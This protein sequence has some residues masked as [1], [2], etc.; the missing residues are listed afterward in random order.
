MVRSIH[1]L[2]FSIPLFLYSYDQSDVGRSIEWISE[3]DNY[4]S[5]VSTGD[6]VQV[7]SIGENGSSVNSNG[8]WFQSANEGNNWQFVT[9]P[10]DTDDNS[11]DIS[12]TSSIEFYE[13]FVVTDPSGYD[14]AFQIKCEGTASYTNLPYA[15]FTERNSIQ[16]SPIS[17]HSYFP[18]NPSTNGI[19]FEN[20]NDL[21]LFYRLV[22]IAVS[23]NV[24]GTDYSSNGDFF[25]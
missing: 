20:L 12:V 14:F 3:Q 9:D 25:A 15:P 1:C 18:T 4:N 8:T 23:S 10:N 11:T 24:S 22:S 5:Y 13:V 7:T 17:I 2:I 6:V 21:S 19:S 16:I